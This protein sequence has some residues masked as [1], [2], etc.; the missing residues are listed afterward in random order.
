[1]ARIRT[2]KPEFFTSPDVARVDVPV[3]ILYQAMWCWADDFGIG[4]TNFNGLL[5]FAFPD[6]DGF[7]AQDVRRF[8]ADI[9]RHFGTT[10]YTVRG[11][12][13]FAIES[14]DAHQK[15]ERREQRRKYPTPDDPDAMPD[16]RIYDGA[17][18]APVVPRKTGAD[19]RESG[20]GTGEQGNSGTGEQGKETTPLPPAPTMTVVPTEPSRTGKP[21]R[22]RGRTGKTLVDPDY[23]PP[24]AVIE[25]IRSELGATNEALRRQH[26]EFIDWHRKEGRMNVD[27][28]AAWRNW[29]RKAG[30]MGHLAA[31]PTGSRSTTDERVA[32]TLRLA[33]RYAAAEAAEVRELGA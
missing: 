25:A 17:D 24:A 26:N 33:E 8:C 20:A 2:I 28:D 18:F 4:E 29:M 10:F 6:S 27:H 3:R 1:M 32:S 16:Q 11:R 12:H 7:T 13:Y 14:W 19:P 21:A 30:R 23:M 22:P 31:S 15:T 5:G 9:A